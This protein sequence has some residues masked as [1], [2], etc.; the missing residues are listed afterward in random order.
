MKGYVE[1][2]GTTYRYR[3]QFTPEEALKVGKTSISKSG[4]AK[5]K[6]A[7]AE[8]RKVM[9]ELDNDTFVVEQKL[10]LRQYLDQWLN[11][12]EQNVSPS[13][14]KRYRELSNNI[15]DILGKKEIQKIT[16]FEVQMAYDSLL[17]VNQ[18]EDEDALSPNTV[19]KVHRVLKMALRQARIWGIIKFNP[20]DD[21]K[22]PRYV[23]PN[24]SCWTEEELVGFINAYRDGQ[25]YLQCAIAAGTG[26]RLGEICALKWDCVDLKE[27]LIYVRKSL[28]RIKKQW[29]LKAPKTK[30]SI[31][32][33]AISDDLKDIL[34]LHKK[35]Q[36]KLIK[37]N[38]KY[39]DEGF[40]C[41]WEDDGRPYN[42]DYISKHFHLQLKDIEDIPTIRFHDIRHTHATI[43]LKKQTPIKVVSERLGHASISITLDFY[44]HVLPSMQKE[45]AQAI[46]GL[47][48]QAK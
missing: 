7:K 22:P 42:P 14:I 47:L 37:E 46:N 33:I 35:R 13:T 30:S 2:R 6:Q 8:M 44:A 39:I 43:L 28:R 34:L 3:I 27:G 25:F 12:Y 26:M 20:C 40:V 16:P 17:N 18:D 1:K 31:R 41:A 5:E 19:I 23:K 38:D 10:T 9:T 29:L 45:A 36:E 15:C 48:S 32:N 24:I 21:I 11:H 4:F